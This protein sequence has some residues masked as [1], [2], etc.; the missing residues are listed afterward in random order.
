MAQA[1]QQPIKAVVAALGIS[2]ARIAEELRVSVPTA[3]RLLAGRYPPT[4]EEA[5]TLTRYLGI[6]EEL[7]WRP[8]RWPRPRRTR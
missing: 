7:L 5:A 1:Q 2:Q 4:P 3:K 8:E 6:A